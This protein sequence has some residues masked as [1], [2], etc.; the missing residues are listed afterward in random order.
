[1]RTN[2]RHLRGFGLIEILVGLVIGLIAILVIGQV[3]A[4]FEGQKRTSTGGSDAQTNGAVAMTMLA[5][6]IRMAGFGLTSPGLGN[7]DGNLLCP[8]GTNIYFSGTTVSNPG[9]GPADG[10]IVAPVRIINGAAG[11]SDQIVVARSDAEFG[12]LTAIVQTTMTAPTIRVNSDLGYTQPGQLFLVG[13]GN[14]SKVCTILQLSKAATANAGD[15]DLEF[16]AGAATPH[17]APNPA[18]S[19]ATFPAYTAGDKVVNL[20]YR[21]ATGSSLMADRGFMYRR[22]LVSGNYLVVADQ[23]QAPIATAYTSANTT[24]LV[25]HVV[26]I[27]GQYG[28]APANSQ[29][30]SQWVEPTG[31]WDASTMSAANISRIKAIRIAVVTRSSQLEKPDSSLPGGHV[32]PAMLTLWTKVN[33]GDDTPPVFNVPDQDYRYKVFTT[34]VPLKNVVWGR[35]P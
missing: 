23:S 32:S 33:P 28:V 9:A 20:G 8:L 18:V 10:G 21:P 3:V 17:N 14:G 4:V 12:V 13:A 35:L 6:E 1:M 15:W 30:V 7:S 29:T 34:I 24:P 19:F 11:A 5:D 31:T 26:S 2:I 25:D 27:Q 22:Y 16:A